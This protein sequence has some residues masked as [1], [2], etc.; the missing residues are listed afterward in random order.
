MEI[1][2]QNTLNDRIYEDEIIIIKY[3]FIHLKFFD[4]F[5][6]KMVFLLNCY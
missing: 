6:R 4:I 1:T 2:Q 3:I 5:H